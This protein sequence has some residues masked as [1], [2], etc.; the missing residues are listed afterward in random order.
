MPSRVLQCAEEI[1]GGC[2]FASASPVRITGLETEIF[3]RVNA[4]Y[5][6]ALPACFGWIVTANVPQSHAQSLAV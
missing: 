2:N 1:I 3:L 5:T 4:R 6:Q